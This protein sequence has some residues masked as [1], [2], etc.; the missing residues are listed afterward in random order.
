MGEAKMIV[1]RRRRRRRKEGWA[2][3]GESEIR[4]SLKNDMLVRRNQLLLSDFM[5]STK[6][7]AALVSLNRTITVVE[8]SSLAT[9]SMLYAVVSLFVYLFIISLTSSSLSLASPITILTNLL[10]KLIDEEEEEEEEE[11]GK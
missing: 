3:V 7:T 8:V 6:F 10:T 11:E 2:V 1:R 4:F 5:A 9:I